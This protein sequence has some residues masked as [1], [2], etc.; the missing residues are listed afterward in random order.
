[1]SE[2]NGSGRK[3]ETYSKGEISSVMTSE[4]RSIVN[5]ITSRS[6]R[7]SLSLG[8]SISHRCVARSGQQVFVNMR[9][10]KIISKEHEVMY[11]K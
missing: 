1:M 9:C 5:S 7:W 4:Q 3:S 8:L 10:N 6:K 2:R 11:G